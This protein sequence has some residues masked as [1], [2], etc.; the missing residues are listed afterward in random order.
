MK[1]LHK[2][3]LIFFATLVV[4]SCSEYE[5]VL[6]GDD[7]DKKYDMAVKMYK[8]KKF[9][10]A[11]PLFE[12]VISIYSKLS[13]KGET[14]YYYLCYSH[15]NLGDFPLAGYYFS[16]FQITYPQSKH[17]EEAAFMSAICQVEASP[18]PSLDQSNTLTAINELQ[19]FMNRY[20]KTSKKDTCNL[21][22]DRLRGK[23]EDKAFK[24]A[25]L[26]YH[27]EEYAAASSAFNNMLSDYPDTDYREEVLFLIVKSNYKLANNSIRE[28]KVERF[29]ETIKSYTKFVDNF[30]ESNRLKE[31]EEY[32]NKAQEEIKFIQK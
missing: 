12:E 30:P 23:L 28:K 32:Y 5:K 16:N 26:Y 1:F 14:A 4:V 17:A 8:K 27:M 6:K 31:L 21:I 10:K 3:I 7:Y 22:I 2:T 15:Y 20:P 18:K 9:L 29:K 24:S 11:V 13:E 19:T 25:K